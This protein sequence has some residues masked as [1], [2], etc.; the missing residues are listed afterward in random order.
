MISK[1][2]R[3]AFLM[4]G[5]P[6]PPYF[7]HPYIRNRYPVD[8]SGDINLAGYDFATMGGGTFTIEWSDG[9]A[10]GSLTIN[11]VNNNADDIIV[12]I[13]TAAA[14]TPVGAR[15]RDSYLELTLESGDDGAYIRVTGADLE[16]LGFP[17]DGRYY[18]PGEFLYAPAA[19]DRD[20]NY[21]ESAF[22]SSG[23][24]ITPE[25]ANR[26]LHRLSENLDLL[27]GH[28]TRKRWRRAVIQLAH[29]GVGPY[30]LSDPDDG[31]RIYYGAGVNSVKVLGEDGREIMSRTAGDLVGLATLRSGVP[32]SGSGW[33]EGEDLTSGVR[34]WKATC[35]V[36]EILHSTKLRV[37]MSAGDLTA[38]KTGDVVLISGHTADPFSADGEY[39]VDEIDADSAL[40]TLAPLNNT[41]RCEILPSSTAF[42]VD[43]YSAGTEE[44]IPASE[45]VTCT[46]NFAP[47]VDLYGTLYFHVWVLED[48]WA[49]DF[50]DI[51]GTSVANDAVPGIGGDVRQEVTTTYYD[52]QR[53]LWLLGPLANAEYDWTKYPYYDGRSGFLGDTR[54]SLEDVY[55]HMSLDGSYR[56]HVGTET[57]IVGGSV[58]NVNGPAVQIQGGGP[59]GSLTSD[60]SAVDMIV[61]KAASGHLECAAD[62]PPFWYPDDVGKIIHWT[63]GDLMDYGPAIV[64]E[65]IDNESVRVYFPGPSQ[66]AGITTGEGRKYYGLKSFLSGAAFSTKKSGTDSGVTSQIHLGTSLDDGDGFNTP[67]L[68]LNGLSRGS[69]HGIDGVF[70]LWPIAGTVSDSNLLTFTMDAM[71][72]RS[73][74]STHREGTG[75]TDYVLHSSYVY[76]VHDEVPQ[77]S[78]LYAISQNVSGFEDR[79]RIMNLDL[80]EPVLSAGA[81]RAYFMNPSVGFDVP[82]QPQDRYIYG[83]QSTP[84]WSAL[85]LTLTGGAGVGLGGQF[86][87][88]GDTNV[89][90]PM[91]DQ[92]FDAQGWVAAD[93]ATAWQQMA[94]GA[95]AG[96]LVRKDSFNS[97]WQGGA[98]YP[99][100][101]PAQAIFS[102]GPGTSGLDIVLND[103]AAKGA[104]YFPIDPA[105]GT[106]GKALFMAGY[107][108]AMDLAYLK[109]RGY[110][111]TYADPDD[112]YLFQ[113]DRR[114]MTIDVESFSGSGL[115]HLY[116]GGDVAGD[117]FDDSSVLPGA[118]TPGAQGPGYGLFIKV[119][120]PRTP[121]VGAPG[122]DADLVVHPDSALALR[123]DSYNRDGATFN[124]TPNFYSATLELERYPF[125]R[126]LAS[127]ALLHPHLPWLS[128]MTYPYVSFN[129]ALR[130]AQGDLI[131]HEGDFIF[132]P[133]EADFEH[134]RNSVIGNW[135]PRAPQ[136]C[137]SKFFEYWLPE[138]QERYNDAAPPVQVG[139]WDGTVTA[140][141][142][143]PAQ[144][145]VPNIDIDPKNAGT[146][147]NSRLVILEGPNAGIWDIVSYIGA[148]A[149]GGSYYFTVLND[150]RTV[151][152][153]SNPAVAYV[154]EPESSW[155]DY[156]SYVSGGGTFDEGFKYKV[157][158]LGEPFTLSSE[159][160]WRKRIKTDQ[161]RADLSGKWVATITN[162]G[163]V[164][165]DDGI[166]YTWTLTTTLVDM[167]NTTDEGRT[168]VLWSGSDVVLIYYLARKVSDSEWYV[169]PIYDSLGSAPYG[170]GDY[171]EAD[172]VGD[173]WDE[174]HTDIL[175]TK[176]GYIHN[177]RS[178]D[179]YFS[180]DLYV[181]D[182]LRVEDDVTIGNDLT[183]E[184][185]VQVDNDLTVTGTATVGNLLF[186]PTKSLDR[187]FHPAL[188][189]GET[190]I[191]TMSHNGNGAPI[192]T[193]DAA[194]GIGS[195]PLVI[196]LTPELKKGQTMTYLKVC[197]VVTSGTAEINLYRSDICSTAA[198]TS[199]LT[200][201]LL[202]GSWTPAMGGGVLIDDPGG[203][204]PYT[205]QQW[206][207][208]VYPTGGHAASSFDY[209]GT[210]VTVDTDE[211]PQ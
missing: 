185:D 191:W 93:F 177:L 126:D 199:V 188:A 60:G 152:L 68:W 211:V 3:R 46:L 114:G 42:T 163:G 49:S 141:T 118:Y 139:V 193:S 174:V 20:D 96:L 72:S 103:T 98:D 201:T 144:T 63:S 27:Y 6:Y 133:I 112:Y 75:N 15:I 89:V 90:H 21:W 167:L 102:T 13:Q 22:I 142:A 84:S 164:H 57:D 104:D 34:L 196:P 168:V 181:G 109:L 197:L 69:A 205:N 71:E 59:E 56:G 149:G 7:T 165:P 91:Y 186:N 18:R 166:T 43:F 29:A 173:S 58:I 82:Y 209:H 183:V 73:V 124:E 28:A 182:N 146:W 95:R 169:V 189:D 83:V 87:T 207:V 155:E 101:G 100:V 1:Y 37:T 24:D 143:A 180:D 190:G 5:N 33:D 117:P 148:V 135:I 153:D 78:G 108:C 160:T 4:G 119:T 67:S 122:Y 61:S 44:H 198:P 107:G 64:Y 194:P 156:T 179:G 150:E 54:A 38:V 170:I 134:R 128:T 99:N 154:I 26:P 97:I 204:V 105:M 94:D 175:N 53:W 140:S 203:G 65:Y 77:Q 120:D 125:Q 32:G 76:L 210:H 86:V 62:T 36:D 121:G 137:H 113:S 200:G 159:T 131:M 19:H 171:D 202:A 79:F 123:Q 85:E 178:E 172:L 208:E 130:I 162:A 158:S 88:M 157:R 151:V 25:A 115:T 132:D 74:T 55:N 10:L 116:F 48:R 145:F 110:L 80:T 176:R 136:S 51:M 23:E 161:T 47:D 8:S 12:V 66:P 45:N 70:W 52:Q 39:Y 2:L 192:Y 184:N 187:F 30:V 129:P 81:I 17:E 11:I 40:Y 147:A 41:K 195:E 111:G 31:P 206:W 127:T 92:W 14:G 16:Y 138:K 106:P 35:D 9:V 50:S